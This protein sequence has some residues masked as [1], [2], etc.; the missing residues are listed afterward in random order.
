MLKLQNRERKSYKEYLK[1]FSVLR[2]EVSVDMDSF[3]YGFYMYGL[4]LDGNMAVIEE[5]E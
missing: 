3:D 4:S 5:N 2:E 1:K